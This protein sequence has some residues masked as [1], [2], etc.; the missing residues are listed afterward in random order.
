MD[1]S[2]VF[3][4]KDKKR[5]LLHY[6]GEKVQTIYDAMTGD[7]MEE[8][9]EEVAQGPLINAFGMSSYAKTVSKLNA[10][11]LPRTNST[12]ERHQLRSMKQNNG[13]KIESFVIRLRVQAEKCDFGDKVDENIKDQLIEKCSSA[14][15]R[16]E[17]LKKGDATLSETLKAAKVF[18]AI[19]EQE[20]SFN[21]EK[22]TILPEVNKIEST[23]SE[24]NRCGLSSHD[25]NDE[26]CPAKGKTCNKCGFKNHFSRKCVSRKRAYPYQNDWQPRGRP[27]R[28]NVKTQHRYE[29]RYIKREKE[30]VNQI[31]DGQ[32]EDKYIFCVSTTET[33]NDVKFK[34]GG[35]SV[36]GIIDSGSKY[37]LVDEKT[38]LRLKAENIEVSNQRKET[39]KSFK[40][41][42]D[43][44]LTVL[45]VFE[46]TLSVGNR[47][48][49][50]DFYVI[51]GDGK[52]L[53]G[54]DSAMAIGVL[55]IGIDINEISELGQ[56]ASIGKIKDVVVEIPIK[57]DAQPVAQPYRRVPLA[58]EEKV[59]KKMDELLAQ[60]VIEKVNKPSNWISPMVVVPKGDDVRIC[61]DMRRANQAVERENHPLPTVE[62]LMPLLCHSKWFS[63]IDV[64]QAFHQVEISENSRHI[65]T[66]ICKKGLFRYTRL[67]FGITCAPE[68]FQKIMEQILSNC[69]GCFNFIDDILVFGRDESEHDTRLEA[70]L[71]QLRDYNVT[72]NDGKCE[73]GVEELVFL[74]HN[75]TRNGVTPTHDKVQAIKQFRSPK[76]AEEVRSFL[77]LVNYIG[78]FIPDLATV[79]EPL[80]Q[81]TKK[82]EPFKW[83]EKQQAAF[84]KL[85][86]AMANEMTL[87]YWDIKDRTILITDASPVGL[88]AVLIQTNEKGPRVISYAAKSLSDVE[89]RY[90]QTEKE[91]LGLVWACERFYYYLYGRSFELHTDHKPLEVIFGPKSRPCARIERWVLRLQSYRYTVIYKPGK[92]NI[93]D[94]LSRL[95]TESAGKT[96]DEVSEHH[97]NAIVEAS[98]PVAIKITE[99]EE[100][101]INDAEIQA[102]K[103]GIYENKWTEE[104]AAYKLFETELC[105]AGDILLRCNRIVIPKTLRQRTLE[106]AHE[107]HPGMTVM[108]RRLRSKVWWPKMDKDVD[109]AVKK[110]RGCIL[111][112]APEP[113]EPLKRKELPSA[114]WQHVAIDFHGP[115][116]SGH[117]LLV[118]VDYYSRYIEIEVMKS[119]E[120]RDTINRLKPIFSRFGLP[121]SITADNGR[122]LISEEFKNFCN[123]NNIQLISTT[124]WWPQM[125][126]EVEVQN[127]A[128]VKRLKISQ[129]ENKDWKQ[130]LQEYL[131][132]YRSTPHTTTLKS[133]SEMM[134]GWNIRDKLPNISQPMERD[135]EV[136]ER[137]K[138]KKEKEKQYTDK[139][140]GAKECEIRVGD[141]VLVKRHIKANKLSTTFDPTVHTV[142]KRNGSEVTVESTDTKKLYRRNVSHLKRAPAEMNLTEDSNLQ[143][144]EDDKHFENN[145]RP[146]RDIKKPLRYTDGVRY[147][148]EA[149]SA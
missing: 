110:C 47:N 81:L 43:H 75:I 96:F 77:G 141:K 88:G 6:V 124:P 18:E 62:D 139:R 82:Y 21:S 33:C 17:M 132:M 73:Y 58:F 116:P 113:P 54:R 4:N 25:E 2:K 10:F 146:K 145:K 109:E 23:K 128:I 135:E 52:V 144:T 61:I 119:I 94:P 105:F 42:G 55:K 39:D 104:A 89:R 8:E 85:K 106:L 83:G 5:Y 92:S 28:S 93:A 107:G 79:T 31:A 41:Y 67:M 126:G 78:K 123:S 95:V 63:R 37:N 46:A 143:S 142:V 70:V 117:N 102:V 125:N 100:H 84:D 29:G 24:C 34:V 99:I 137:D 71:K 115:L 136:Y 91:A 103:K 48:I 118:V 65:T 147:I 64:R 19:C 12:Y 26:R 149:I 9:E 38:W 86:E 108:K 50:A 76:S 90:A 140:R 57:A 114:P 129:A 15:M 59:D 138:E 80:R 120:S 56:P 112:A 7:D 148:D 44:S 53:I 20:K 14:E 60:G 36:T 127:R 97:V 3:D 133:P 45:G 122:Q 98:A 11:F 87:G 66:F 130:D 30:K 32:A 16:R 51:Q 35:V 111:V 121:L 69:D 27:Q 22:R 68:L 13:E 1:A 72:I 74:G 49:N 40:A 131:L 134:F 101:T